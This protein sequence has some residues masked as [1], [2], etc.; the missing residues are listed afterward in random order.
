MNKVTMAAG[1]LGLTGLLASCNVTVTPGGPSGT[2]TGVTSFSSQYVTDRT[3]TDQTGHT[4]AQGT[5][6]IC[7]N[8]D[9]PLTIG[10]SW[11][12][13]LSNVKFTLKGYNTGGSSTALNRTYSPA[14]SAGSDSFTGTVGAGIAPL[15]LP[16][17][18]ALKSQSITVNPVVTNVKGASFVSVSGTGGD[19][20]DAGTVESTTVIIIADCN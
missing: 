4:Y 5:Y 1:L 20:Y 11:A 8:Y 12:G 15:S 10:Y 3:I 16:G 9:T 19:G 18:T 6:L 7:D 13:T 17:S 2:L 14:S